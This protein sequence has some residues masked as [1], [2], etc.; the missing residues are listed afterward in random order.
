VPRSVASALIAVAL[1][2]A[3]PLARAAVV[4]TVH[5]VVTGGPNAGTY[6]VSSERGGCT[7][8]FVGIDS[9]G[10]QL[11]TPKDKDPK[12]FNSLQ[13]IVP[14]TKK[15]ASGTS[16]FYISFGFGP[17]LNRSKEWKIETRSGE[18]QSGSGT[19]TVAD[20]GPT[21]K[22]TFNVMSSDGVKFNG[23]IDCKSV[24]R[25]GK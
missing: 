15:A 9:W 22:V 6:D 19:V 25:A 2:V 23:T 1:V 3:A 8:G 4:E 10:N 5:V 7:Y 11:S 14:S 21:A 16:E 17:L 12:H 24:M 20:H 18:K 13:L